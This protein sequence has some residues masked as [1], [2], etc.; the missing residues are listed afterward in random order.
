M[1]DDYQFQSA[2]Y[3]L[4]YSIL[5]SP[6]KPTKRVE[7]TFLRA[8]LTT[9]TKQ[10][11][12]SS[13]DVERAIEESGVLE[14]PEGLRDDAIVWMRVRGKDYIGGL[15]RQQL[16]ELRWIRHLCT[17]ITQGDIAALSQFAQLI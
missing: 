5:H 15:S 7:A 12:I 10:G 13:D 17:R 3:D 14:L 11:Y 6:D 9:A 1:Y 4:S 16:R 2:K 8:L